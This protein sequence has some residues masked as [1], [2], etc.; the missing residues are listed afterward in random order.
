VLREASDRLYGPAGKQ[1]AA[2]FQTMADAMRQ[3][4]VH[5]S[6]WNLPDARTVYRPQIRRE[7]RRLLATALRK[8]AGDPAAWAR[9]VEEARLWRESENALKGLPALEQFVVDARAYNGGVWLTDREQVT[10][11]FLRALVGIGAGEALTVI[12]GG[13][14]APLEDQR[15]WDATDGIR[16]VPR[17]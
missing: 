7:L 9:V 3:T 8:T 16:L 6:I 11:A 4:R 10:G 17:K 15:A 14:R 12:A 1:M 2:Y 13:E 5:G